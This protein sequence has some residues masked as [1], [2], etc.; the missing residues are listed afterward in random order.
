[1]FNKKGKEHTVA[2]LVMLIAVFI[3][4]YTLTLPPCDKCKLMGD[5]C[6][7]VCK[8]DFEEKI[9][10]DESPG[11]IGG[12][13]EDIIR[14]NLDSIN[15]FIKDKPEIKI[16]SNSLE[17]KNGLFGES[18]QELE[19]NIEDLDS[20]DKAYLSFAVIKAK[21]NLVL[22]LNGKQIFNQKLDPKKIEVV[23]LPIEYLEKDNKLRLQVTP[24]GAAFWSSNVY[25]LKDIKLKEEFELTH[26]SEVLRFSVSSS[27]VE[28][29][30]NSKLNFYV[31]CRDDM[32]RS[33]IMK[34]YLN[35]NLVFNKLVS[36]Q[37]EEYSVD[38]DKELFVGGSNEIEFSVS[39]GSYLINDINIVNE[40]SGDI[41]PSY[42]FYVRDDVYRDAGRF[43]LDLNMGGGSKKAEIIVND[44]TISI[45]TTNKFVEYDIT[46][47]VGRGNN[48]IEIRPYN[49]FR[50]NGLK[51]IYE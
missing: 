15:L 21:G 29:V 6:S 39:G 11:N 1:M 25:S 36:C 31:Y 35:N 42:I 2:G 43:Y 5:D 50:V 26:S 37:N 27:E 32:G 3:I 44:N 12:I 34:A 18:D 22:T 30:E 28:S 10:L 41:F 13:S 19:F 7:D 23:D 47:M 24:P 38:L 20:L 48:Y 40:V 46:E 4:L 33:N 14:H 45:D 9:I 8:G 51:I 49:D 16:L 17:I